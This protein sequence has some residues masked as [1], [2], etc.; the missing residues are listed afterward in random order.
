MHPAISDETL[1]DIRR[2]EG[3]RSTPYRDTV[4][5]LT[6][7]Y[8]W[9]L[10]DVPMSRAAAEFVMREHVEAVWGELLAQEPCV[11]SMPE[12]WRAALANMAYNLGVPRLLGFRRMWRALRAGDGE[13]AAAEALNSRWA[14]QV[15]R[16]AYEVA[17]LCRGRDLRV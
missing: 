8:G 11:A 13:S 7:G 10:D 1:A 17:A 6:I 5:K 14:L 3:F 12:P 15:G 2:H 9:N 16:R 4:G